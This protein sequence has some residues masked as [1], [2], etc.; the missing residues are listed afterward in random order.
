MRFDV[1]LVHA[2]SV[3]DF[4]HRDDIVFAYLGNSD[5]VHVS[6]IFEMPPVGVLALAQHLRRCGLR[7]EF[8][9]VASRMLRDPGF[10]VEA[11][12]RRAPADLRR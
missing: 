3:Y 5:S 6:S 12:F 11:F 7:A 9:N 1:L 10:D 8:F 4:R 2:P